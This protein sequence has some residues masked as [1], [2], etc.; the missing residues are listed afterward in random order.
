MFDVLS[1]KED[2]RMEPEFK[3]KISG[4]L[5]SIGIAPN[6]SGYVYL[7]YIIWLAWKEYDSFPKI[8]DLFALTGSCYNVDPRKVRDNLQTIL[9]AY[10]NQKK[11]CEI[12]RNAVHY[13]TPESITLKEFISVIAEHLKNQE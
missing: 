7:I 5:N 6:H 9:V 3:K 8:K 4:F 11:N 1:T 10:R 13:P 2:Y 12:F